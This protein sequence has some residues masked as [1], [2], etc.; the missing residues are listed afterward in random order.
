MQI[1]S[2]SSRY[3]PRA[4][5]LA[6]SRD[7]PF[8][9]S[10]RLTQVHGALPFQP[11]RQPSARRHGPFPHQL[12][13]R[14]HLAPLVGHAIF[15]TPPYSPTLINNKWLAPC[16]LSPPRLHASLWKIGKFTLLRRR[17]SQD[18][19]CPPSRMKSKTPHCEK[20]FSLRC[21]LRLWF[22]WLVR[23]QAALFRGCPNRIVADLLG[24]WQSGLND[25]S[26]CVWRWFSSLA[27][28]LN[29]SFSS[30]AC[31]QIIWY[32]SLMASTRIGVMR[33]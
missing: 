20:I 3:I 8:G 30:E 13:Q 33:E 27:I 28:L 16:L 31:W 26:H 2:A 22:R 5:G 14:H 15:C 7:S 10:Q 9:S 19:Q 24:C 23:L 32:C 18:S 25:Y 12:P 11:C 1:E 21:D 29:A 4:F 17:P 6:S